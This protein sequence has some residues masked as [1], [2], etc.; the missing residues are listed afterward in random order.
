[1]TT[2]YSLER[3]LSH[4]YVPCYHIADDIKRSLQK[5]LQ[6]PHPI[7]RWTSALDLIHVARIRVHDTVTKDN[8]AILLPRVL[9]L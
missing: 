6:N 2:D 5:C 1:M 3:L 8:G 7:V 9:W 4:A